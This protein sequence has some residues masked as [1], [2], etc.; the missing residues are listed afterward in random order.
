MAGRGGKRSTSF[1]PGNRA[2]PS[3]RPKA[4]VSLVELAR[5]HTEDAIKTLADIMNNSQ[6]DPA[7]ATAASHILDR[8]WGKPAQTI[9]ATVNEKRSALDW[10]TD[11]LV[12]YISER[13]AAREWVTKKDAS[14]TEPDSVPENTFE[15]KR[16]AEDRSITR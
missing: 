8:G 6:S 16:A 13:R 5:T 2:N 9:T 7:R 3:G 10:T 4:I 15:P 1:K 14:D 11:E 12:T